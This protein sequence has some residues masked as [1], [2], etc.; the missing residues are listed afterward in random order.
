MQRD[1][2]NSKIRLIF[3]AI[4]T[5]IRSSN[6]FI[7]FKE[8]SSEERFWNYNK[9]LNHRQYIKNTELSICIWYLKDAGTHIMSNGQ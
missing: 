1:E 4:Y 8:R 2:K 7:W 6:Y 9:D 3:H 5:V